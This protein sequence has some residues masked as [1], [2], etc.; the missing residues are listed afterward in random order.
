MISRRDAKAQR[1]KRM[2][3]NDTQYSLRLCVS[4][5]KIPTV[6]RVKAHEQPIG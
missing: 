4:A 3:E 2:I 5:G 1:L 6:L